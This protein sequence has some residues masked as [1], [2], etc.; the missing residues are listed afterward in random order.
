MPIAHAG[1]VAV[2]IGPR[3][4]WPWRPWRPRWCRVAIRS[5]SASAAARRTSTRPK[6]LAALLFLHI[7]VT[8]PWLF[9]GWFL[10]FWPLVVMAIAFVG[11]GFGELFQRRRQRV[12]SEPLR[13]HGRTAA[14]AARARFLGHVESEVHYSLLLLSIGVLYAALSVL[15]AVVL[16]GVLAALAAN[17]SLWYL[18]AQAR[19]PE[20]LR[21]SATVADSAGAVR[22]G[23]RAT[24]IASG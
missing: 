16:Y 11:V 10:R 1:A 9:H 17:G 19:R 12:L 23:R 4:V 18:L 24:S 15:A 8:M 13:Q 6:A 5:G 7:R 3:R 2:G 22:A 21:A 14:A 20:L